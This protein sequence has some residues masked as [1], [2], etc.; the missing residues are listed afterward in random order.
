MIETGTPMGPGF[1]IFFWN[2][3]QETRQYHDPD[4]DDDD[5]DM[6]IALTLLLANEI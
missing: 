5:D 6:A 3:T 2:E 4:D 1:F